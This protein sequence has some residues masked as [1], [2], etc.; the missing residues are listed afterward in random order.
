L[1]TAATGAWLQRAEQ[2]LAAD[3][4]S[5]GAT[6]DSY[7]FA[8]LTIVVVRDPRRPQAAPVLGVE[9]SGTV[10]SRRRGGPTT[11]SAFDRTFA[12]TFDGREFLITGET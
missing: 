4:R 11:T 8:R 5:G 7:R 1:T 3:A 2:Q 10:R 9:A 6:T 12:V